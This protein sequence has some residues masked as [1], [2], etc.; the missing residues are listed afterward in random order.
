[1]G[2]K[3]IVGTQQFFLDFVVVTLEKKG[4]DAL[5]GRGWLVAAKATQNWKW[6]TLAIESEDRK[7]IID[8]KNQSV[9]QDLASDSE[10]EDYGGMEP[11]EG[12][13]RLGECSEDDTCFRGMLKRRHKFPSWI[14]SLVDGRL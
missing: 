12:V 4:Y 9:S 13:L 10:G 2:Q 11:D 7:Y 3:V 14:I 6:N 8:L 5:L 1:M